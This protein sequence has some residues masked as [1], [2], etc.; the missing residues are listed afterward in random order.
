MNAPSAGVGLARLDELSVSHNLDRRR[1]ALG[2][3]SRILES[4]SPLVVLHG[5]HHSGKSEL[6]RSWIIPELIEHSHVV[7]RSFPEAEPP[8]QAAVADDAIEVWDGAGDWW[9]E[10]SNRDQLLR[11]FREDRHSESRRKIVLI[12]RHGHLGDLFRLRSELPHLLEEVIELP[13]VTA[14]RFVDELATLSTELGT[15]LA[16]ALCSALER[17]LE[18][19]RDDA[20]LNS[21]LL[22][23]LAFEVSRD[24]RYVAMGETAYAA[25]GG[26]LGIL[27]R[28]LDFV[29]HECPGS[30]ELAWAVLEA[31]ADGTT[32]EDDLRQ[33]A[34]RLDVPDD[35]P[36]SVLSWFVDH[37][38]VDTIGER[39]PRI[40]PAHLA[41]A[42]EARRVRLEPL[43]DQARWWLRQAV[44]SFLEVGTVLRE[45][46][47]KR[48]HARRRDLCTTDDEARLMLRCAL[49][50]PS[51]ES[52]AQDYWL[53][54]VRAVDARADTLLEAAFDSQARVREGAMHLM[55]KVSR[56]EIWEQ[57]QLFALRDPDEHVR[58]AAVDSLSALAEQQFGQIKQSLLAEIA[59]RTSPYRIHAIQAL[60]IV[61]EVDVVTA[62]K[63]IVLD[64]R[65][66]SDDAEARRRAIEVLG[67]LDMPEAVAAL[68]DLALTDPDVSDRAAA[69]SA[70]A[71]TRDQE[72]VRQIIH[73]L[74]VPP[75]ATP[76]RATS[77]E[78]SPA[79]WALAAASATAVATASIAIPGIALLTLGRVR[80]GLFLTG[81]SLTAVALL[82][83]INRLDL[84]N[85]VLALWMMMGCVCGL[86][87]LR[88]LLVERLDER[89]QT[90]YRAALSVALF[91]LCAAPCMLYLHGLGSLLARR[92]ARGM[93][94]IILEAGGCLL[95]ALGAVLRDGE[96]AALAVVSP[97]LHV[98]P[99][100]FI[101]AGM[102]LFWL[103][104]GLDLVWASSA[105]FFSHAAS[106]RK[107]RAAHVYSR[108]L[109][110]SAIASLVGADFS[111]A[112]RGKARRA[113][114]LLYRSGSNSDV[115]TLL[116]TLWSRT[117]ES[118]L[119]GRI[120]RVA[121][122]RHD[123]ASLEFLELAARH[124]GFREHGLARLGGL[125][126]A[127]SK[128][129]KSVM[130]LM[131]L[132]IPTLLGLTAF[133]SARLVST[134]VH[135]RQVVERHGAES[136]PTAEPTAA[137]SKK[138][139]P[140]AQA[141][142]KLGRLAT[143]VDDMALAKDARR[144]LE[145]VVAREGVGL[146]LRG[147]AIDL[148]VVQP[149]WGV[150]QPEADK[151]IADELLTR[152]GDQSKRREALLSLARFRSP[153]SRE[154]FVAHVRA[155]VAN[156]HGQ[157]IEKE[158]AEAIGAFVRPAV[159]AVDG[160]AD[161]AIVTGLGDLLDQG[162]THGAV[163]ALRHVGT[164][165]ALARLVKFVQTSVAGTKGPNR[166]ADDVI[167]QSIDAVLG[168]ASSL[169]DVTASQAL[170]S[171]SETE[172]F[173]PTVRKRAAGAYRRLVETLSSDP[174][175]HALSGLRAFDGGRFDEAEAAF[176]RAARSLGSG[177]YTRAS[178]EPV[179]ALGLSL[180]FWLH[181]T[182]AVKDGKAFKRQRDML[183]QLKRF[184]P[185][186]TAEERLFLDA[187]LVEASVT[188]GDYDA[189]VRGAGEIV[190]RLPEQDDHAD[191]RRP[192]V[193]LKLAALTLGGQAEAANAA[194]LE[195]ENL[196]K[197]TEDGERG[198][199]SFSGLRAYIESA[200]CADAERK[201]LLS[202]LDRVERRP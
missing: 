25:T 98:M 77:A 33:L 90:R 58:S 86:F 88:I 74:T 117:C 82:L 141:L 5:A 134:P 182:E 92:A 110:N 105:A 162:S 181:E 143:Q 73:E 174:A 109:S 126:F 103:S 42:I 102:A 160:D 24:E 201:R 34:A 1:D 10:P 100:S 199:W 131:A 192:L 114:S 121:V 116:G 2:L 178:V 168:V 23:I 49:A 71:Q 51:A 154:A 183:E 101:V 65:G 69:A 47:F 61:R 185:V 180:A 9:S 140:G 132:S 85:G 19:L 139:G 148:I 59:S 96:Q 75:K 152:L 149:A 138:T 55:A 27:E 197:A 89:P 159:N 129:P 163:E 108:M 56:P 151:R 118:A 70:L 41:A 157:P 68:L 123:A 60:R 12:L 35:A 94:C 113:E 177:K 84:D 28:F 135:L 158:L 145:D 48:L 13:E 8:A 81:L 202:I 122:K 188:T 66:E 112:D 63:S 97:I 78:R 67:A 87:P 147:L 130:I 4:K 52:G 142:E 14:R 93:L 187:N 125:L 191:L 32:G 161:K 20:A 165:L 18:A 29:C 72:R 39:G 193:Y 7:E 6:V 46:E 3:V 31:L 155:R 164:P 80:V 104:F 172:R 156:L 62:L 54:R 186:L 44:R 95:L 189:A 53:R 195:L 198:E 115:S 200:N 36:Q 171:W 169:R 150:I 45:A 119:R 30:L 16:H 170:Q 76:R 50:Y 173:S 79:S 166:G 184:E 196:L 91:V 167:G 146:Y 26:L 15:R 137:A 38:L 190:G 22:V 43:L 176:R 136:D 153:Q 21:K 120:L 57:L 194:R 37:R 133:L 179:F 64:N 111:G 83:G 127:L 175:A 128:L 144:A 106:I 124:G 17:D 11:Q 40:V 99:L 107:E